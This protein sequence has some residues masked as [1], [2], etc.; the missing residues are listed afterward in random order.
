MTYIST[1]RLITAPGNSLKYMDIFSY[2]PTSIVITAPDIR[3]PTKAPQKARLMELKMMKNI[4][5]EKI[6][7][8][9]DLMGLNGMFNHQILRWA[10]HVSKLL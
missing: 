1:K 6:P 4:S 10:Y 9:N 3:N 5:P 8:I 7:T 2:L